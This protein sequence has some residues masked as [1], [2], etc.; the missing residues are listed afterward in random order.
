MCKLNLQLTSEF[1]SQVE[2]LLVSKTCTE[3]LEPH[4]TVV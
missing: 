2:L 3:N 1:G 4:D